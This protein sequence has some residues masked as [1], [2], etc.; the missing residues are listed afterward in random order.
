MAKGETV[1]ARLRRFV[2]GAVPRNAEAA[3]AERMLSSFHDTER[4]GL[5]LACA[6]RA[7]IVVLLVVVFAATSSFVGDGSLFLLLMPLGIAAIGLL[8]FE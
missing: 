2:A 4:T 1:S 6:V 7:V 3:L 5:M 8:Q